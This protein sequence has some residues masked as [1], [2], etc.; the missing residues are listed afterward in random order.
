MREIGS[1]FWSENNKL[2]CNNEQFWNFGKDN[3]FV[4]SGRTAIFYVLKNILE[5]QKVNK[6]YFPSYS[7][8]SMSQPFEEFGIKIEYYDVYFNEG[9]KYNIN[10]DEECDIF[11]AMNYFG[12]SESNMEKYVK[13]FKEKGAIIIED[14]THSILSEK[15]FC[16]DSDYL[17]ASLRKWFPIF[18]G[19]LAVN[20]FDNFKLELCDETN[21]E[22]ILKRKSAMKNK[23]EYLRFLNEDYL[24]EKEN[25]SL[26]KDIDNAGKNIN[27]KDNNLVKN[28]E[29]KDNDLVKEIK[30]EELKKEFLNQYAISEELIE[31]SN[32]DYKID[33]ESLE[34]LM[35][36]DLREIINRRKE[37]AKLIY[38]RLKTN[39]N[40]KFL[41]E[42]YKEDCLLFVPIILENEKRNSL[43]KY[44]IENKIYLPV[45]WP[46]EE[47]INNV[48]ENE[49][50][51]IC[52][53]RY[54]E[55]E[56]TYYLDILEKYFAN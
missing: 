36:I 11:F 3:K 55:Q 4:F 16:E 52:D 6:V 35:G 54:N 51:L 53:Q 42:N 2:I 23:S 27:N 18:C 40:I 10:L 9:L 14:I 32:K 34:I 45:H 41:F 25:K 13:K 44:L 24:V 15:K 21:E 20:R 28:I 7:C 29:N 37:N 8:T 56:I 31:K 33:D 39:K 48:F 1:D 46:L 5:K 19:G 12:Y 22:M 38:K 17:V 49:L 30:N 47:K 26:E 43:R 50:S